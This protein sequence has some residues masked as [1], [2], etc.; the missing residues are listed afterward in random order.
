[1]YPTYYDIL[2][3]LL[4]GGVACDRLGVFADRV[5]KGFP[6]LL[7][8]SM[9]T[10]QFLHPSPFLTVGSFVS[11]LIKVGKVE[12][13]DDSVRFTSLGLDYFPLDVTS[14]DAKVKAILED[15]GVQQ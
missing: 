10:S 11:R 6:T 14:S 3:M 2:V 1:M 7:S 12:I 9:R 5:D 4:R 15:L 13:K 8:L